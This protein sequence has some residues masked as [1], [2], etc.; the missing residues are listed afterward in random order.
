MYGMYFL[1]DKNLIMKTLL[2]LLALL[3]IFCSAQVVYVDTISNYTGRLCAD[4]EP[5][6]VPFLT[7]SVTISRL[8]VGS[9]QFNNG[10]VSGTWYLDYSIYPNWYTLMSGNFSIPMNQNLSMYAARVPL[11][12]YIGYVMTLDNGL[13]LD[14]QFK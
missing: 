6:S 3:P 14:I 7:G 13:K 10:M 5:Q 1:D 11:F 2:F 8:T 4:I 9:V 12:Q